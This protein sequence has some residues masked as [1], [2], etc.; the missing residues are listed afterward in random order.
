MQDSGP[1]QEVFGQSAEASM[2]SR[3][4]LD[5]VI[6]DLVTNGSVEVSVPT[7]QSAELA[8]QKLPFGM[9]IYVPKTLKSGL[10]QNLG[11]I[12]SLHQ[13]G[14]DPVPH[15]AARQLASAQELEHF[16]RQAVS[17][18]AVHRVM[19]IGGDNPDQAGPF[20]DSAAVLDSGILEGCGIREVDIAGYPEGHPRIAPKVLQADLDQKIEIGFRR[21]LGINI[22]TQFSFVP[23]RIVEYCD[24]LAHRAPQVPV[25]VGMAGPTSA[26][27]LLR[28]ARHCGVSESLRALSSLGVKTAELACHTNPDEQIEVLARYCAGHR[29]SS[30]I[31]VHIFSFGGFDASVRW[32][33]EK[34]PH[35][36]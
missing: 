30:V 3:E 35:S 15:I 21:G 34:F 18:S 32:M 22:V 27:G 28:F 17:D 14:F 29:A 11:V 12:H 19:L 31:G 2:N 8:A 7:D 13:S 4:H 1:Q 25:Y 23:S 16:L 26:L 36:G 5:K 10:D 9:A 24:D 6:A 33:S 20:S